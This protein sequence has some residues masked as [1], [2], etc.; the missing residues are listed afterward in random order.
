MIGSLSSKQSQLSIDAR[1]AIELG[2]EQ[3]NENGGIN[4]A[5]IQL[6][7]KDDQSSLEGALKMHN[8]FKSE[9]IKL[10]IGHMTSNMA[11]AVIAS[12]SEELLFLSPSM[13]SNRFTGIDDYFLRTS[14]LTNGQGDTFV[15]F[16][17][18]EGFKHITIIY[19]LMNQEYTETLSNRIV[20]LTDSFDVKLLPFDSREE[21]LDTALLDLDLNQTECVLMLSQATDTAYIAQKIRQQNTTVTLASVSWSM[22]QDVIQYGGNAVEGMYFLGIYHTKTK[23]PELI[24]FETRFEEKYSYTPSFIAIMAYD[25]LM[26]LIQGIEEADST[27]PEKVKRSLLKIKS[28]KGLEESFEMDVYGDCNRSYLM[29]QLVDDTFIPLYK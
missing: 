6:T 19:D 23:S 29:Y 4:G 5:P 17:T 13:S 3:I 16:F 14:P 10:L 2:I 1:N 25:A 26:V 11:D 28:F 21:N 27:E 7:V 12:Q 24:E 20:E 8:E 15:D 22:T 9:G 18:Q